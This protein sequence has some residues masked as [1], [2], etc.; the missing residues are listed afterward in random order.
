MCLYTYQRKAKLALKDIVVY[1]VLSKELIPPVMYRYQ[2]I[3]N[4][5]HVSGMKHTF[6][7]Y[8]YKKIPLFSVEEGLHSF[9]NKSAAHALCKN[10]NECKDE[11]HEYY[12]YKA[13]IPMGSYYYIGDDNDIVSDRLIIKRKL[14]LNL[15]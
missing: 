6:V 2:Y 11:C 15:F 7:F 10:L 5:I 4:T 3:L 9:R 8:D 1:K 13:I 12:V 14:W